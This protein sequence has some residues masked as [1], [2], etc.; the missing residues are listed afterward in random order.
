M[1]LRQTAPFLTSAVVELTFN[2]LK[3]SK[4][5]NI[6][7]SYF[8][9]VLNSLNCHPPTLCRWMEGLVREQDLVGELDIHRDCLQ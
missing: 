3:F 8:N 7:K 1:Y 2:W 9:Y 6:L 5:L 4:H